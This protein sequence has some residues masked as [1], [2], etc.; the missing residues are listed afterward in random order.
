MR[1]AQQQ[2]NKDHRDVSSRREHSNQRWGGQKPIITGPLGEAKSRNT[3]ADKLAAKPK[4][5]A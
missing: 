1:R 5:A 3:L 4:R 2:P